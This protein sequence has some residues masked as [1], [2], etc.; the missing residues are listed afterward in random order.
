[1]KYFVSNQSYI[2]EFLYDYKIISIN[3]IFD[4]VLNSLT[5]VGL[6]TETTGLD[7]I[8][9]KILLL[10][11][12]N[13]KDQVIFHIE[14][15]GFIPDKLKK[16]LESD[17]LFILQNSK[18]DLKFLMK[19]GVIVNKIYDTFLVEKLLTK[20]IQESGFGL[21]KLTE[22]YF[23]SSMDKSVRED[24]VK[25]FKISK[26][27]LDYSA[28]DVVPLA[29]IKEK[30]LKDIKRLGMIN[31]MNIENEFVKCLSY[32]E[33]CGIKLDLNKWK[34]RYEKNKREVEESKKELENW[35]Y[36]NGFTEYFSTQLDLF[37]NDRICTLNWNSSKQ[38][39][40]LF[41]KIGINTIFKVKGEVKESID[42]KS[43]ASQV[44]DFEI[45][46]LYFSYKGGIKDLT[47]YGLSWENY[48]S[49][50]TG[51]IHT[52]FHQLGTDTGRLSSGVSKGNEKKPNLQNLPKDKLTRSCFISEKG[53][54]ICAT[55]F[56]GQEQI[57]LANM[58][59]EPNLINFY[60]K[61]GG[62]G[63]MHSYVASLMFDEL[64]GL[65]LSEIQTKHKDKRSIAKSCGFA[66]NYGGN[67]STI[68]RNCNLPKHKGDEV[69]ENYFK[70]FPKLKEFFD[71]NLKIDLESGIINFN[72]ICG[73]KYFLGNSEYYNIKDSLKEFTKYSYTGTSEI[74]NLERELSS[75]ESV[76][77]RNSK[78]YRIQGTS[79]SI[80]K[81]AGIYLFKAIVK[82]GWFGVVKIVNMV[83]D[84]F[85]IE[86]PDHLI[87]E[88]VKVLETCMIKAGEKFCK[89]VPL[90]VDSAV[91]DFWI[92]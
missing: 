13:E 92:H 27:I 30:Q 89:I 47:T 63:D 66:I 46:P 76:I 4:K 79:A 68:A 42:E 56:C 64:S 91:G 8:D 22:K 69:Y 61:Y 70:A 72:N 40:G 48:I 6:D 31:V 39:K 7:C 37:N 58:S 5:E 35:I 3:D 82:K 67:G 59:K 16:Y 84:E 86:A 10:Q 65:E 60:K 24:I 14:T 81:L 45:L 83:H 32:M 18:F 74:K 28:F 38:V 49:N 90:R 53:H 75:L 15:W 55:D 41:N 1:M 17:R 71:N 85:L 9:D 26:D 12:G 77:S 73:R 52:I 19:Y 50:K 57:V 88:A 25:S 78:N 2:E 44:N 23:D 29:T 34:E 33:F 36:N 62:N 80:S 20:G 54:K 43:L 87:D 51:R 11:L 21:A